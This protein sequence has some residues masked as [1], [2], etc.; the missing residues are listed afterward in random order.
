[1]DEANKRSLDAVLSVMTFAVL[2]IGG[3]FSGYQY[4]ESV[5]RARIER[6]HDFLK[7]ADNLTHAN[8]VKVLNTIGRAAQ[9]EIEKIPGASQRD[10]F[11]RFYKSRHQDDNVRDAFNVRLS[12]L[13]EIAVCV[14][15]NLC[16]RQLTRRLFESEAR[17]LYLEWTVFFCYGETAQYREANWAPPSKIKPYYAF[18]FKKV[19]VP[20]EAQDPCTFDM[21]KV[22][23]FLMK[24]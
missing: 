13:S 19:F 22:S 15:A 8:A 20:L 11:L 23:G 4:L 10:A 3:V 24:R 9:A 1:M 16:E 2:L 18:H 21:N 17:E 6:T 14:D 12:F 7:R 5:K